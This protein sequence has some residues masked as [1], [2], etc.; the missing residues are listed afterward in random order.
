[1][2]MMILQVSA[3]AS[4]QHLTTGVES[5]DRE[6]AQLIF[7]ESLLAS[8]CCTGQEECFACALDR[9]TRCNRQLVDVYE[10]LLDL[11]IDHFHSEE[12][13]MAHLPRELAEAHKKEHADLSERLASLVLVP[14]DRPIMTKPSALHEIVSHWLTDHITQWDIP[15]AKQVTGR[16]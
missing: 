1:M 11:L 10:E 15:L 12:R 6:H 16:Y 2:Q 4:S 3:D 9:R 13:L 8:I 5:I 14:H 7:H